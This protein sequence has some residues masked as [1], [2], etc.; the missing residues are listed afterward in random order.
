MPMEEAGAMPNED[1]DEKGFVR[2]RAGASDIADSD[3]ELEV[4]VNTENFEG[5][6]P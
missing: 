1:A 3:S 4:R 5:N 6:M 2:H